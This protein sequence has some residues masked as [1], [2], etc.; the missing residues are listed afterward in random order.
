MPFG[1][2]SGLGSS[3][4][5]D[6]TVQENVRALLTRRDGAESPNSLYSGTPILG[7]N[8]QQQRTPRSA[9]R[10]FMRRYLPGHRPG[11]DHP[12][13]PTNSMPV[14][15]ESESD[16]TAATQ[17]SEWRHEPTIPADAVLPDRHPLDP[18][19]HVESEP[20]DEHGSSRDSESLTRASHGR[21]HKKRRHHHRDRTWVRKH[22][23]RKS[24]K[25]CSSLLQG[26]T[27]LKCISTIVS[28][29]FLALIL[30]IC[31]LEPPAAAL[32]SAF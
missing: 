11:T 1:I 6:M 25:T 23:R 14:E 19:P 17:P 18:A 7:S 5:G 22:G 26:H 21:R 9:S 10:G 3:H 20:T 29:L 32:S 15:T 8:E 30:A 24:S 27:R 4:V 12:D 28:G 31:T 13:L 2:S 16:Y